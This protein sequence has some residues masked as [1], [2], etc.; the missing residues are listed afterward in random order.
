MQK[1]STVLTDDYLFDMPKWD[2]LIPFGMIPRW[3]RQ[4]SRITGPRSLIVVEHL[5]AKAL[6]NCKAPPGMPTD[7]FA[8]SEGEPRRRDVT[9]IGGL[10]YRPTGKAW[11]VTKDS[12]PMTFLAQFRFVES[13]DCLGSLPGAILLVFCK[14]SNL[15][16]TETDWLFTE[17]YQLGIDHLV[18][19]NKIPKQMWN[20][21]RWFGLRYRTVD[22]FCDPPFIDAIRT[23]TADETQEPNRDLNIHSVCRFDGMKIGGLPPCDPHNRPLEHSPG[24]FLCS[25]GSIYPDCDLIYPWANHPD[26]ITLSAVVDS[27]QYL[28]W[29]DG[30]TILFFLDDEGSIRWHFQFC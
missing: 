2:A 3:F 28:D 18:K 21:P 9:K 17:W 15:N 27:G 6:E 13:L 11:P 10:P 19:Q 26:P 14:N 16:L 25:L 7:V 12:G 5:R 22:F 8:L 24:R 1:I 4:G 20:V 23:I 29:Y 30:T